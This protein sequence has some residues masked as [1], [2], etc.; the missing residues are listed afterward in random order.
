[1]PPVERDPPGRK[2]PRDGRYAWYVLSVL[3]LVY[4]VNFLDRQ[5]LSILAQDIKHALAIS[6]AQIGFLY[7]TAFA[8]FYALFGIP[9]GRLAD[10]WNRV[11]L[12]A[13]G[14]GLWSAMTTVSGL[15]TGYTHL[16]LARMGVGIGEASASPAAY[17]LIGDYFSRERRGMA[18]AIYTAGLFFGAGLALPLGGWV[19]ESWTRHFV[20]GTAPFGLEGWQVAFL[21]MGLPG[22]LLALWVSTLHEPV[23]GANPRGPDGVNTM[24]ALRTFAEEVA[25]I[26]PPLTLWSVSRF[27]GGLRANLILLASISV[28]TA[29]LVLVTGDSMQWCAL[30]VGVYA[31]ASWLQK[32]KATDYPA[33]TLI[34]RTPALLYAMGAFACLAF[35]SY[36]LAFWSAPY[37]MRT[38]GLPGDTVGLILGLPAG[39]ATALGVVLGGP[40]SDFLR[41]RSSRGRVLGCMVSVILPPPLI[42]IGLASSDLR[43]FCVVWPLVMLTLNIYSASI[44]AC[45]QDCLLPRMRATGA[46][47]SFLSAALGLATG[48]Y[49]IGRISVATD[50]LVS[51]MLSILVVFPIALLL[52][53]R[54]SRT[55]TIAESTHEARA[56]A[57]GERAVHDLTPGRPIAAGAN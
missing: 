46:A 34:C 11:R 31:I 39:L 54:A 20:A 4:V 22:L 28:L 14:L 19:S 52:L 2:P 38:F 51:G 26:L 27:R 21:A 45:I 13:L 33:Y 47:V 8:V 30:G 55:I 6:D 7:G 43:L 49:A 12:I 10:C 44:S 56:A 37:A 57:A 16:T 24:E 3:F 1:M 32:L 40:L 29:A 36:S 42:C 15:A 9:L 18:L 35:A 5:L 53:W 25:S 23:R 50:S 48:P 41:K 17:S